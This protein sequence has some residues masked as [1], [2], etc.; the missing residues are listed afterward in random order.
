MF[1]Q[2]P[3]SRRSHDGYGDS[4]GGSAR[5]ESGYTERR[6]FTDD[7]RSFR[8]REDFRKPPMPSAASSVRQSP[9]GGYRGRV[10][11]PRGIRGSRT[12]RDSIIR[13]RVLETGYLRK[14]GA[15]M[16]STGDY[17]RRLKIN[18]QRR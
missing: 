13:R 16:R 6:S 4:Y 11:G 8:N 2:A 3:S 17:L 10:S 15:P 5:Y 9:R 12:L 14:R 7:R 1:G 18:R